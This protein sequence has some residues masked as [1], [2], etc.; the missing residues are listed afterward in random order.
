MSFT[1][2]M[3][4]VSRLS[5]FALL[6]VLFGPMCVPQLHAG[7]LQQ[8][9]VHKVINDVRVVDP[10]QAKARPARVTDVIKDD[11]AVKT[12]TQSR[13]ELLFQDRTLTRL[14]ADTLF[15]FKPGTRNMTL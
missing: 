15:S 13:A 12:G 4:R 6:S 9:E 2:V 7:P 3:E 1:K 11:L 8:A 5:A 10:Q 14:G